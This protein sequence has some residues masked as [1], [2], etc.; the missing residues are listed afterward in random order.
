MHVLY[1]EDNPRNMLLVKRIL[2]ADGHTMLEATD[3]R[4]GWQ[5]A[6]SERPSLILV[7][8]HLPGAMSGFDLIRR[9]K[10]HPTLQQTPVIVLTAYGEGEV[11]RAAR[12][13][14]CD[15]FLV[16]PADIRQ[17]RAAINRFSDVSPSPLAAPAQS[18]RRVFI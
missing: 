16:K 17:I 15:E 2:E 12:A 3:G 4:A 11:E 9:L 14:G 8:L 10:Q 7:D 6:L 13:A 18:R 5:M 1:V